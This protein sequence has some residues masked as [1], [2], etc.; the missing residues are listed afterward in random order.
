MAAESRFTSLDPGQQCVLYRLQ[1]PPHWRAIRPDAVLRLQQSVLDTLA[2]CRPAVAPVPAAGPR[3]YRARGQL[4]HLLPMANRS[5]R[6]RF[7]VFGIAEVI[8]DTGV[9]RLVFQQ[10]RTRTG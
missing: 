6:A 3:R 7:S 9:A 5:E 4:G 1:L 10:G 8:D 2:F